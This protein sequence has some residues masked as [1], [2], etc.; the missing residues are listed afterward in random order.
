MRGV[1]AVILC[2]VT[3]PAPAG[4]MGRS[5]PVASG[6]RWRDRVTLTHTDASGPSRIAVPPGAAAA[7]ATA[8]VGER[9]F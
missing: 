7:G 8:L 5:A 6:T 1:R 4:C 3:A 2:P 9:W